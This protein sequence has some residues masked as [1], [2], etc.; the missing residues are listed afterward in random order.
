MKILLVDDEKNILE[1][2][3][4]ALSRMGYQVLTAA[5]AS[6]AERLCDQSVETALIDVWLGNDDGVE[7]LKHLKGKYPELIAVMISGHST[8]ATAVKAIKF[9]AYD[10]LEKPLSLDK[11]EVLFLNIDELLS[12]RRQR[13]D[14]LARLDGDFK[15]IGESPAV[16]DLLQLIERYAP[17]D[18]SVMITGESG[19]GKELVARLIHGHSPRA[20]GPFVALNCA[21]LPAELAEAELFG[22]EKG[23]F[24]GAMKTHDGHFRRASGGVLFLDEISEMPLPLQAKLL[25]VIED[26]KVTPLGGKNTHY[27]DVR[28]VAA[29]NRQLKDEVNKDKFRQDLFF[30]L[31]VLPVSVPPLRERVG[32][33]RLLVEYFC[34]QYAKKTNKKI[35][36][37]ALSGIAILEKLNY[38]GN[39]R[40]LKNYI[41]RILIVSD[42]DPIEAADVKMVL[43]PVVEADFGGPSTLKQAVDDFERE[44]ILKTIR[45]ANDNMAKAA[46]SLGLERSHLYKKLKSLGID[47]SDNGID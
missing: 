12:L 40:E 36:K 5:D 42:N 34:G 23:A 1:S 33:I 30:R 35:R 22:Y 26:K 7:L 21:A 10:F 9:G 6:E 24:T 4:R 28:L 43:S 14:L 19:S 27:V 37:V 11:L 20:R 39:I 15:L 46:R 44:Y 13:D 41:E 17:E 47:K 29:S 25:R 32:D 45:G 38:P 8:I 18:A 31:N 2:I 16:K 3:S